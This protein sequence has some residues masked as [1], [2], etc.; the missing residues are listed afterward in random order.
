VA[1]CVLKVVTVSTYRSA[2]QELARIIA[3]ACGATEA[4]RQ[5]ELVESG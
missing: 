1:V 5:L 4:V 3:G 2:A